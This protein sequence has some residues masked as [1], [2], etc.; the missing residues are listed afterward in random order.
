MEGVP[1]PTE[2]TIHDLQTSA[3]NATTYQSML[4]KI[5]DVEILDSGVF[6]GASNYT[7]TN[8][9][10]TMGGVIRIQDYNDPLVGTTIPASSQNGKD[11]EGPIS[12]GLIQ[13]PIT[14]SGRDP[15][16]PASAAAR[17][18]DIP[19]RDAISRK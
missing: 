14:S 6:S 13:T 3:P 2:I 18:Q 4:V 1:T 15:A 8:L 19:I 11:A 16:K 17:V 9:A 5:E 12:S 10:D 7:I